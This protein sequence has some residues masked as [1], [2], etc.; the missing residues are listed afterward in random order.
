MQ[1]KSARNQARGNQQDGELTELKDARPSVRT[2]RGH[3]HVPPPPV[4]PLRVKSLALKIGPEPVTGQTDSPRG[5]P[6]DLPQWQSCL[7]ML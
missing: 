5:L 7:Q 4:H 2:E 1:L 3:S 6:P